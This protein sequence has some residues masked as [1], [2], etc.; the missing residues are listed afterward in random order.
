[1]KRNH[2]RRILSALKYTLLAS[3]VLG[4]VGTGAFLLW[5]ATLKMPSLE[6]VEQRRVEQSTKIFDR[7]GE[8]LLYDLHADVKR[9]IV[10][11]EEISR[12]IKNATVA[13][14][15]DRFYEHYGIEPTAILRA[16]WTNLTSL[17][18]EQG[19]STITQQVVKNSLLVSDKKIS[20]KLKEWV[21][22]VRL[23]RQL[24]KDKILE[25]YLNEAP[26]GGNKYGVEE[27]SQAFFG[28]SAAEI[29]IGE[30]AYLAA[31]PQAP[32]YYS[33]YGNNR[34]ELEARKNKVLRNM[35]DKGF[36]TND[37]YEDA[38]NEEV[39]FLPRQDTGIKAPH[40]VFQVI[41]ELEQR[42]GKQDLMERG[43]HVITTLDWDLQREAQKIVYDYALEN[44][45]KYNAE[46]AALVAVDPQNGDVLT[47]VGSR[48]YFD[49]EI[50]GNFN[51]AIA[52]RQPGSSFKPFVYATALTKG[53][54]D[55]TAVFDVK[56]QFSTACA[57]SNL[58]SSGDCYSPVNYDNT[59]R[60]PITFRNA[61][62]QSVNIPAIKVLYL[63]GINE[64][65]G[66]AQRMG[67]TSLEDKSRYGLTL[68]L[69]GGEVSLLE[70]TSA[71]G[72]FA[73]EGVRAP[74]RLILRVED[75][76]GG[77]IEDFTRGMRPRRVLDAQV[78]RMITDMLA[79]NTARAPA[80]GANSYLHFPGRDVAAKTGTTNE[81]RDA[82][83]LGYTPEIA[84]GA[85]AGNNDN[86]PMEKRVAGFIIAPLWNEVMRVVFE[87]GG[88][89]GSFTKPEPMV[90]ADMKPILRGK[91][92]GGESYVID[93]VTGKRATQFTPEEAR[94][95]VVTGEVHSI[96]HWVDRADPLGPP[97]RNPAADSQYRLWEY[98]VALWKA[99][100]GFTREARPEIPD[101]E[102]D[103]H[104]PENRPRVDIEEPDDGEEIDED[105]RV[106][107][108]L[109]I[110][111]EY[112]I[113]KIEY[114]ING[115]FLTSV[116]SEPFTYAFVPSDLASI[117]QENTLT[118]VVHDNVLNKGQ[119]EVSFTVD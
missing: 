94:E 15:D 69:G 55:Q 110:D 101:E 26:Y 75:G 9:T 23:E 12:N 80:F 53:Y 41:E 33:P 51:V 102:D 118:V 91:W 18:F 22:A 78:S 46:N 72:V 14:E 65:L 25:L 61:L 87:Q 48:D 115:E 79:D 86:T 28:K 89:H 42:Y 57:P 66:L 24:P 106:E 116:T 84:V 104:T 83:I 50:D 100:S 2:K 96:L 63:A 107:I 10:P 45:E 73:N 76:D 35:R 3:L 27:A 95:E 56:T 6:S 13:I 38:R 67:I 119:A 54:T 8:V 39:R 113:T 4:F 37:E 93:R 117:R 92:Q 97:P 40:F 71:Y 99:Q 1:M 111:A 64:S 44:T 77:V 36:I 21:L 98:G 60:G 68:V 19:G 30:A 85:W 5:A 16:V 90:R 7:S 17:E 109:D 59:F 62:A 43:M 81:Y 105:E 11:I 29:S 31:L 34:K 114:F 108:E 70:M 52:H 32:T 49:E 47:M 82:W 112:P 74:H 58:T 103:V 20:R 88:D